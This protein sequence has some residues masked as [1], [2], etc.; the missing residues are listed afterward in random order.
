V[1]VKVGLQLYSVREALIFDPRW[2]IESVASIGYRLLELSGHD[3]AEDPGS[4][5]GIRSAVFR[6]L[7]AEFGVRFV[8]GKVQHLELSN[9]DAVTDYYLDLGADHVTIAIG[10]FPTADAVKERAK[11][12]NVLG[13]RCAE[14]G[15]SLFYAHHYHELQSVEGRVVLDALMSETDPQLLGLEFNPYWLMRGLASPRKIFEKYRDRIRIVEQ[16][17]F[18]LE[19]I[20]K[21]NMWTFREHHPIAEN[22][23]WEV[24]L[25]GG[26]IENIHPVQ[27][28]LF[29]EIG[30]GI[31]KLQEVVDEANSTG[32][33]DYILL[34]QDFTRMTSEFDSIAKSMENY[35]RLRDVVWV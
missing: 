6:E 31:V 14:K 13:E 23:R 19:E 3:A 20:A 25:K 26:E 2:T 15:L 30:E 18:P 1:P 22:I 8:G 21:L 29:T 27:C 17:D 5:Y 35:R 32:K 12:Y 7:G 10:Y 16:Q 4:C 33:V 11:T 9:V 34:R 28:S 24:P